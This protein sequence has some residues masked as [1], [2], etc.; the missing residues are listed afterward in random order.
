M[1]NYGYIYLIRNLVNG[2]VYVGQTARSIESRWKQHLMDSRAR[3]Y[4]LYEAIRK[5]GV[6]NF[7]VTELGSAET[8]D[9]LNRMEE[10]LI[11]EYNSCHRNAGYNIRAG[12]DGGGKLSLETRK[13]ISDKH[14][15][16]TASNKGQK[17]P[18]HQRLALIE[19]FNAKN[20]FAGVVLSDEVRA[21]IGAAN[22]AHLLGSK[23]SEETKE[24]HRAANLRRFATPESRL[25]H[26]ER[27]KGRSVS[28]ETRRKISEAQKGRPV[29]QERREKLRAAQLGKKAGPEQL[30]RMSAAQLLWRENRRN[31]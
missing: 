6:A 3:K 26:G 25:E 31:P 22:A 23:K 5:Y 18:E 14:K 29:P 30:A 4:P 11:A 1:A 10:H 7:S 21:K 17:M 13:K 8:Q 16:R 15:G 2:K 19:R 27:L 20:P 9:E 28:E 24:K 12:G